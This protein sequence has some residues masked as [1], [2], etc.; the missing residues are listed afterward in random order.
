M[1]HNTCPADINNDGVVDVNDL[2]ELVSSWGDSG[3]P[4][5][6]DGDGIVGVNDL[7]ELIHIRSSQA[8]GQ[9][10]TTSDIESQSVAT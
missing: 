8:M 2:L 9:V 4:G 7:L 1:Y 5:D 3:G 10:M 6:I